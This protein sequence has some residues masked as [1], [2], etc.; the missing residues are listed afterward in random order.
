MPSKE[1]LQSLQDLHEELNKLAPAIK[2]VETATEITNTV[3]SI[4]QMH[5][6]LIDL[7]KKADDDLKNRLSDLFANRVKEIKKE[8][9]DA[10]N[11]INSLM[12]VMG[13]YHENLTLLRDQIEAYYK[14][15]EEINFPERLDKIDN[16]ISAINI[17]IQNIQTRVGDFERQMLRLIEDLDINNK[18]RNK[19]NLIFL[20]LISI[21]LLILLFNSFFY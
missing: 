9:S 20:I 7:L 10:I 3:K 14:R 12:E 17:G 1:V 15:I 8:T 5:I 6:E 18:R 4:P 21:S 2:H 19:T 13:N 16:V 11:E